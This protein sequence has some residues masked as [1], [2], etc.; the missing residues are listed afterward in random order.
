MNDNISE[1]ELYFYDAFNEAYQSYLN[2]ISPNVFMN[3]FLERILKITD[4]KTGF[5]A[6]INQ[7]GSKK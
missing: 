4:S 2:S 7:M 3:I 5:I 6:S 1:W